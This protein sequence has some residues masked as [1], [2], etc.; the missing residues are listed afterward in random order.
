MLSNEEAGIKIFIFRRLLYYR[1]SNKSETLTVSSNFESSES[2]LMKA[3]IYV[4][5]GGS[6]CINNFETKYICNTQ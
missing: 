5:K 1:E 3:E 4:S 6:K 2:K